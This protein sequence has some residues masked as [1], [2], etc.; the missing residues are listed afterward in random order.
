MKH[1]KHKFT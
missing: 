1:M